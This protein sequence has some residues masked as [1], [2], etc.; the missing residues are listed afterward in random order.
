MNQLQV[1]PVPPGGHRPQVTVAPNKGST[2]GLLFVCSIVVLVLMEIVAFV[3]LVV[4]IYVMA[5]SNSFQRDAFGFLIPVLWWCFYLLL[6]VVLF[7]L[8]LM[9]R[10]IYKAIG[11]RSAHGS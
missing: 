3:G 1:P 2:F 6:P 11:T 4:Q 10:Q 5:S 7:L 8:V 9:A